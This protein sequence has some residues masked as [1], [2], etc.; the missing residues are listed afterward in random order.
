MGK[1]FTDDEI[2]SA[3]KECGGVWSAAKKL[4][5]YGQLVHRRLKKIGYTINPPDVL[6]EKDKELIRLFYSNNS[7]FKDLD[8]KAFSKSINKRHTTVCAIASEMGLT[9]YSRKLTDSQK[10]N[11]SN[12][13]KLSL[14][15]NGHPRGSLGMK[16]SDKSKS[17]MS[18]KSLARAKNMTEDQKSDMALKAQK[19]KLKK[20]GTIAPP[21]SGTTWKSA[22]REIGGINKYYRSRWEANYARY[23]EFLKLNGNIKSWEHEPET[24]WFEAIKR[25]TRSYLPDFRVTNID[26]SIEYHEVKGWMDDRSKTKLSRMKKYHPKIKLILIDAKQYKLIEKQVNKIVPLWE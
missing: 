14:Q 15:I 10:K 6:T 5:T 19:T 21:R 9:T 7:G 3:Y 24:F 25:G 17:I 20:Y 18:E 26:G 1:I 22:W 2:I 12:K 16:H 11:I 13:K 23:L 4:G 8:L